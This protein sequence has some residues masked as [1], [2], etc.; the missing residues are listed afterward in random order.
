MKPQL[1][2]FDRPKRKPARIMAHLV[3]AGGESDPMAHYICGKCGWDSGWIVDRRSVSEIKRGVP[4][5]NC[6]AAAELAHTKE[7]G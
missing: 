3:D 6:N 5:P 1:P 2:G 4:C 7:N